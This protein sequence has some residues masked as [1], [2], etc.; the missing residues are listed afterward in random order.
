MMH[1][2]YLQYATFQV[3]DYEYNLES[4][5]VNVLFPIRG[6]QFDLGRCTELLTVVLNGRESITCLIPPGLRLACS[7]YLKLYV[8]LS[9]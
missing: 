5:T 7:S 3:V 2:I 8:N 9:E 1:N 4:P 6:L